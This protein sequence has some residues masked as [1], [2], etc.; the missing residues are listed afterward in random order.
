MF[1]MDGLYLVY[2]LTMICYVVGFSARLIVFV[3][4]ASGMARYRVF[5]PFVRPYVH[6]YVRPST[7][8]T[9]LASN[10]LFKSVTLKPYEIL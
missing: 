10:L 5:R 7:F 9:T 8:A 3:V 4:P 6:P 1:K 2:E